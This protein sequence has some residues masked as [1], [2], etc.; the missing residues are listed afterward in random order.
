MASS[1]SSTFGSVASAR[2]IS[3]RLRPGVPSERAGAS[4]SRLMPTRSSTA[5][6]FVSASA[7]CGGAQE[8]ADHDVLQHRHALERLRHLEGAGKP[9]PRARFRREAA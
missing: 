2:A 6:A 1:S 8:G 9:E 5:R 3:S 7:R 4:A